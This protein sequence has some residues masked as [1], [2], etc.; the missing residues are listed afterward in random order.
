MDAREAEWEAERQ[1]RLEEIANREVYCTRCKT[2]ARR[3]DLISLEDVPGHRYDQVCSTCAERIKG[4]R[5]RTCVQCGATF[6]NH[7]PNGTHPY[8]ASCAPQRISEEVRVSQQNWR[9]AQE[10]LVSDLTVT[11]W[12]ATLEHFQRMCA[13]CQAVP[14]TDLEHVIP[15]TAGGG[16]TWTNCVPACSQCNHR[17]RHNNIPRETMERVGAYLMS[18][19]RS[20]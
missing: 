9:T 7:R 12:L 19:S 4:E 2:T 3:R 20:L 13:Y 11:Q 14:F 17:K 5:A 1:T 8:C 16:T 15:V 18:L 6:Y 10:G